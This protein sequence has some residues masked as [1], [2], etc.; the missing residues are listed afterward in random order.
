MT[1]YIEKSFGFKSFLANQIKSFLSHGIRGLFGFLS[2]K[3]FYALL[4]QA[5][6][7][8]GRS[9]TGS[10]KSEEELFTAWILFRAA[11]GRLEN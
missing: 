6:N 2:P 4:V 10:P 1:H 3:E 11:A 9:T 7:F 8:P 5:R